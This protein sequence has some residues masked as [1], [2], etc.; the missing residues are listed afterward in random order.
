MPSLL[1]SQNYKKILMK[2]IGWELYGC[3]KKD[4]CFVRSD[5]DGLGLSIWMRF[6]KDGRFYK[7]GGEGRFVVS[8][9]QLV[10]MIDDVESLYFIVGSSKYG[11]VLLECDGEQRFYCLEP[12]SNVRL[13]KKRFFLDVLA[14]RTA[15]SSR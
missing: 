13:G 8:G 11:L 7:F 9:N 4:D 10:M 2:S 6:E 1:F 15:K 3:V 14:P 5:V 12:A